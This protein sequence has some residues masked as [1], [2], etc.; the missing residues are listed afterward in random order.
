MGKPVIRFFYIGT[1][2]RQVPPCFSFKGSMQV[3]LFRWKFSNPAADI[4]ERRLY[5]IWPIFSHH[6]NGRAE[7]LIAVN[8]PAKAIVDYNF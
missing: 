3:C 7:I 5:R 2:H 6:G 1:I 8:A 4:D